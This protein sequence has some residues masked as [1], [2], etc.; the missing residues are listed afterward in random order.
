M[1]TTTNKLTNKGSKKKDNPKPNE[2]TKSPIAI[3]TIG[4]MNIYFAI[5][6]NEAFDDGKI[7]KNE[8]IDPISLSMYSPPDKR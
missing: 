8:K 4:N 3:P 1:D 2:P 5:L 7:V 6:S